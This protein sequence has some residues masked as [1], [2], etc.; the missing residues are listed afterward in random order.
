MNYSWK[1]EPD[2]KKGNPN[3]LESLEICGGDDGTRTRD[4]RRDRP[5]FSPEL[6]YV[7][8]VGGTGIEPVTLG[9]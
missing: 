4:L 9:L 7:P 3:I 5:A 1:F 8:L 2:N 6:N